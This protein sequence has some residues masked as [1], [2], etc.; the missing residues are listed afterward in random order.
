MTEHIPTASFRRLMMLYMI[1]HTASERH[2]YHTLR[3]VVPKTE[4][5]RQP[6]FQF[7]LSRYCIPIGLTRHCLNKP[8]LT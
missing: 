5:T 6:T 7:V 4:N 3:N 1:S 8:N 2:I